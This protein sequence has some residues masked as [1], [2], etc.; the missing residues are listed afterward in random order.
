[1]PTL[2][3]ATK[4]KPK[5]IKREERQSIYQSKRWKALRKA[6][7]MEQPLC[8]LC[9][10]K[11]KVTPAIDIHHKDSFLNYEGLKRLEVAYDF[12]NLLSVCKECHSYLHRNGTTHG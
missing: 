7:L 8:E 4:E 12:S 9:L 3:R 11:G 6:K 5:Q 2:K 10:S 1:M